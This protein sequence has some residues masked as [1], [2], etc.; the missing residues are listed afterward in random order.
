MRLAELGEFGLIARLKERLPLPSED[1]IVGIDDDA[2]VLKCST[3]HLTLLAT[4]ALVEGV[5]FN[6]DYFDY[7]QVGWRAMAANLSDIAAM[8]GEPQFAVVSIALPDNMRVADVDDLY[9]GLRSIAER[10]H[11]AIVGGDTTSSPD[12]LFIAIAI[13]GHV[14]ERCLT[15]R[16]GACVGDGIFVTGTL[17]D[18][19][20]GY[21]VLNSE[22]LKTDDRFVAITRKHLTPVPRLQEAR[23]LVENFPISAMI[24]ISDGLASEIHHLCRSGQ[25]GAIV[26]AQAIPV[27][28]ETPEVASRFSEPAFDYAL[29]G[30]EDY[31]LLFT[32]PPGNADDLLPRFAKTFDLPC[33]RI[34]EIRK[35]SFGVKLE[36]PSGEE[37]AIEDKGFDHFGPA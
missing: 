33:T 11:T 24:D 28:P 17:G 18:A 31:E 19:R 8:G 9:D 12:G 20:C 15:R 4:D 29:Y 6:L 25:V 26:S 21:R 16:K 30:G 23:F 5:H 37:L 2:A 34:G 1:V 27:A 10:S 14:E 36:M 35:A 13:V 22:P 7:Y 32:L 3:G